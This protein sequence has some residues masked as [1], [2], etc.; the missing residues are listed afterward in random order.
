MSGGDGNDIIDGGLG[1]DRI[2]G[3]SGADAIFGG[4]GND[5][6]RRCRAD[7]FTVLRVAGER[8][9]ITDF[10]GGTDH[11]LL[12]GGATVAQRLPVPTVVGG[13]TVLNLGQDHLLTL[14]GQTGV[15]TSWFGD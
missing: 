2:Y 9:T 13:S 5:N 7:S 15:N 6:D 3:G 8:D 1:N 14:V 4:G 11:I 10:Q 12:G